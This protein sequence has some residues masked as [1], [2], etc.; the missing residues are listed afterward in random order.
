MARHL[1]TEEAA[2]A[3]GQKQHQANAAVLR[4]LLTDVVVHN[5]HQPAAAVHQK[6]AKPPQTAVVKKPREAE[7]VLV[8]HE[9]KK[10]PAK[11]HPAVDVRKKSLI[12]QM[13][14]I[15]LACLTFLTDFRNIPS[16]YRKNISSEK[17]FSGIYFF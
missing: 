17:K 16:M 11:D 3:K 10:L 2:D 15:I 4:Q 9:A 12:S 7:Q 1:Q 5:L 6:G 13:G 14:Q 8:L